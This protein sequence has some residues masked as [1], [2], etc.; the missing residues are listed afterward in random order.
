MKR[1]QSLF[2]TVA[3]IGALTAWLTATGPRSD[4]EY[5]Q[6]GE[7]AS[8]IDGSVNLPIKSRANAAD[9]GT[10]VDIANYSAVAGVVA[11]GQVDITTGAKYVVLQDSTPGVAAWVNQDSVAVDST[12][13]KYY[14]V[15]YKGSRRYV[16]LLQ[17]ASGA[18]GDTIQ[19]VGLIVRSGRR[20][21]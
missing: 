3:L 4:Y 17:R 14:D 8:M 19:T 7:L 5:L 18:A 13:G 9:S 2:L 12:D 21:R 6:R 10:A 11:T 16:R 15:N 1:M 20:A